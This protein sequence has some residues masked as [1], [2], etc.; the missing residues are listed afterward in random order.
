MATATNTPRLRTKYKDEV[1]PSLMKRFGGH[2]AAA[3]FTV[4]VRTVRGHLNKGPR[5]TIFLGYRD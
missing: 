5:H 3:G 1:I 2:A 4:E